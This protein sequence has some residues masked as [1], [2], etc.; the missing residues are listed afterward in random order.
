MQVTLRYP[1][2]KRGPG[3]SHCPINFALEIFG[4]PWSLLIVRDVMLLK[5]RRFKD[6]LQSPERIATNVLTDRLARL[7]QYGIIEK[8]CDQY[9]LTE[10][11]L[12]LLPVVAEM[13]AWGSKYDP[14]TASPK[15]LV[16][17]AR[18][19]PSRYRKEL[20]AIAMG[21]RKP[22]PGDGGASG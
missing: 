19:N 13:S 15:R 1:S 7:E 6:F 11:G 3:K 4:D 10:K 12:D 8:L 22:P 16:E 17:F 20:R 14:K 18:G 2:V 21:T 9:Y 5:K